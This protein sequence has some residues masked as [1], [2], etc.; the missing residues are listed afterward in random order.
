MDISRSI[1][2]I[3]AII[4]WVA[5]FIIIKSKRVKVLLPIAL[6]SAIVLFGTELF[7]TSLG[8]Y[9]FN[10]PLLPIAEIPLFHLIWGAGS[11]LLFVHFLKKEF[12]KK[13]VV[14]F[15]FAILT[16]AFSYVSKLVDNHSM[17]GNFNPLYHIV[18][19]FVILSF[20]AWISEG[21]FKD[22]IYP[23]ALEE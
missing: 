2:I 7:F 19:N 10:N 9:K 14:V 1:N 21:L 5:V 8:L 15:V 13:I 22:R 23:N 16:E 12:S 20:L 4:V 3:Y 6:L 11:G 17:F 18:E